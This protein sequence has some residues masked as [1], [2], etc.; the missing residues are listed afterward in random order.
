M[1]TQQTFAPERPDFAED[2]RVATGSSLWE[3]LTPRPQIRIRQ[4]NDTGAA[5]YTL[6]KNDLITLFILIQADG[7]QS[8]APDRC[9]AKAAYFLDSVYLFEK[10]GASRRAVE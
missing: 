10:T 1:A 2:P 6:V 8:T 3:E 4:E 5:S 9:N 7:Q